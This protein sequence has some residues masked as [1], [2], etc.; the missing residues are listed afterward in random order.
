[1]VSLLKEQIRLL[2]HKRFSPSSEQLSGQLSLF[3]ALELSA[4]DLLREETKIV[5]IKGHMR[6]RTR[7]T[8]DKLPDNLPV[9]II[10]HELNESECNCPKCK[11]KLH[12][13]GEDSRDELVI[14][15]AQMRIRRHVRSV[16]AC[17]PCDKY[18]TETPIVK[19]LMPEPVIK[20]SFATPEAIAHIATQKFMMGSPLYRQEKEWMHHGIPLSRQTM[21]NWLIYVSENF[22]E[23]I[24][25]A[26]KARLIM[27]SV[28]HCDETGWQVLHEE[29]RSAKQK[30][31]MWHYRTSGDSEEQIVW[32]EYQKDRKGIHPQTFFKEFRGFIHCDGYKCYHNLHGDIV[33]VGCWAHLRRRFDEALKA[34]PQKERGGSLAA[35]GVE[36]LNR[37]FMLEREFKDL[38]PDERKEK[39]ESLS[40]PIMEDFFMWA[41]SIGA[42]PKSLLGKAVGYSQTQRGY[43]RAWLL[44]G[45]LEISNNRA[46]RS[47]RPL[48][49]VRKNSLF[50]NTLGGA[51][52]NAVFLSLI[53]SARE[54]GLNPYEYLVR[55]LKEAPTGASVES[56]LPWQ[57]NRP[58]VG[59]AVQ[60]IS[61]ED[62]V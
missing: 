34:L 26:M 36:W 4:D 27:K 40:K 53:A 30:G 48:V 6:K 52:A 8:T 12:K 38:S 51:R 9:D 33:V 46:E 1:M 10:K 60:N 29:G 13:M 44:D 2:T 58:A 24:Y 49:I 14:I 55:V 21:S 56:L 39:R 47:I 59:S 45:R 31:F 57:Q 62:V 7:L 11:A 20:G 37:L 28:L 32:F 5:D 17:R 15:P 18:G 61:S 16:Y 50:S 35:I 19:A 3:D 42:L 22:L 23:S 25:D 54:N 43:L 41:D